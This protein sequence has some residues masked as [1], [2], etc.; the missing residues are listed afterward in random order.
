MK[1][2]NRY[3]IPNDNITTPRGPIDI[4]HQY[5][6]DPK[7]IPE[8]DRLKKESME[9]NYNERLKKIR[10]IISELK[11]NNRRILSMN[12]NPNILKEE[13]NRLIREALKLCEIN[14]D[15]RISFAQKS[16]IDQ[17]KEDLI[18]SN[19]T[20]DLYAKVAIYDSLYKEINLSLREKREESRKEK[21]KTEKTNS[22]MQKL[23]ALA[24]TAVLSSPFAANAI[25]KHNKISSLNN[26]VDIM[27]S[28][29]ADGRVE[30][31]SKPDWDYKEIAENL[32]SSD[33]F[34]SSLYSTIFSFEHTTSPAVIT[35]HLEYS[36]TM[37]PDE[38]IIELDNILRYTDYKTFDNYLKTK[39]YDNLNDFKKAMKKKLNKMDNHALEDMINDY[40][41]I[42]EEDQKT[43]GG[44]T[45]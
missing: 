14:N 19:E 35:E 44:K 31:N 13:N 25:N 17:I 8:K 33:D 3:N 22:R 15:E 36:T 28:N 45:I 42:N 39:G 18:K 26:E 29:T 4:H 24:I 5:S 11:Y 23:V 37:S 12:A 38:V 43:D 2:N 32:L 27:I 10:D 40:Q 21:E 16:R 1:K 20:R 6:L 9:Y 7:L 30:D 34:D 41:E